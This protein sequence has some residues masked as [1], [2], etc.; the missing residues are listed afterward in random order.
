MANVIIEELVIQADKAGSLKEVKQVLKD[1]KGAMLSAGDEGSADFQKLAKAAAELKDKVEDTNAAID[2]ANPDKFN[3]VASAAKLAATGIQLTTGAMALFGSESEDVQ[4]ALVKVQTA[5]MFAEGLQN[6]KELG[7]EW[8]N[9]KES[10]SQLLF[11]TKEKTAAT[12]IDTTVTE[13]ATV[14]QEEL[15]TA[16]EL[17][18]IA[19]IVIAIIALGAALYGLN[20]YMTSASDETKAMTKANDKLQLSITK[21]NAQLVSEEKL[22]S[23]HIEVMKAQGESTKEIREQEDLLNKAKQEGML[24][25]LASI[26]SLI[27]LD[28]QK[29]LD[30]IKND[31]IYESTLKVMEATL[32]NSGFNEKADLVEKLIWVNKAERAKETMDDLAKQK[33][34]YA[35]AQDDYKLFQDQ[36]SILNA[37]RKDEDIKVNQTILDNQKKIADAQLAEAERINKDIKSH[38]DVVDEKVEITQIG[39]DEINDILDQAD[40]DAG[41]RDEERNVVTLSNAEKTIASIEKFSKNM[42]NAVNSSLLNSTAALFGSLADLSKK[43]AKA[44]KSFA[45]AQATINTYKGVTSALAQ[46]TPFPVNLVMAAAALAAGLVQVRNILAVKEDGGGGGGVSGS[47]SVGSSPS[48]DAINTPPQ[49]IQPS[50]QLDENGNVLSQNNHALPPQQVYVVESDITRV[51]R[52]VSVTEQAMSFR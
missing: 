52:N 19:A 45:V 23:S 17:N 29:A 27:A 44:Q 38:Q 7:K 31:S 18:P 2:R 37:K 14:A 41:V 6:V 26:K 5:M 30:I 4:K 13:G 20:A 51:Q 11:V 46:P 32:R 48:M 39:V 3:G 15:N 22:L 36:V 9:V 1:I 21:R 40:A 50:T 24:N 8:A 43:N 10:I 42:N 16:M 49:G 12:K 25:N 33:T 28:N 34:A 47:S 35:T